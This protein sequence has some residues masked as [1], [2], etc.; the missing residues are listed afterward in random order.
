MK[1][2]RRV[3]SSEEKVSLL[4]LHLLEKQ[5]VSAICQEH[6]L[7]PNVFYRWQQ[8]FFAHGAAAF[9]Q[10]GDGRKDRQVQ[11]LEQQNTRLKA[12]LAGKDAVIA[13]IMASHIELKKTLGED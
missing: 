11:N 6:D 10:A 13:E 8:E 4:R 3:F 1:R 12:K 2:T 9:D 7:K 5:P